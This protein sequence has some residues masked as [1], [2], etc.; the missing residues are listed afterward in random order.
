MTNPRTAIERALNDLAADL[1]PYW[2]TVRF[3][4]GDDA[5][6]LNYLKTRRPRVLYAMLGDTDEWAHERR[7]DLY[8]DAAHRGDR[9]IQTPGRRCRPCRDTGE[10]PRS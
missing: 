6:C 5:G 1:P 10:G 7:Y 9:F 2:G 3:D 8:L 4:G